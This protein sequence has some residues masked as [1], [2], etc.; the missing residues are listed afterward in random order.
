MAKKPP[1][2]HH[3]ENSMIILGW[4]WTLQ[5]MGRS[6]S[7]C[8]I[9]KNMLDE[10]PL[11]TARVAVTPAATHLFE[12][13]EFCVRLKTSEAELFYHNFSKS[14]FLCKHARPDIQ[15]TVALLCTWVK[16]PDQHD[17]KKLAWTM[18]YLRHTQLMPLT[19]EASDMNVVKWWVDA[20]FVVHP[21]MRRYD[22][23]IWWGLCSLHKTETQHQEFNRKWIGWT[24]WCDATDFLDKQF[25]TSTRLWEQCYCSWTGQK[26][27]TTGAA[28]Q[29][30]NSKRTHHINIRYFFVADRISSGDLDVTYCP[31]SEMLAEY[32]TKPLWLNYEC[33]TPIGYF[34]TCHQCSCYY[35]SKH[36]IRD[37]YG[38]KDC[39]GQ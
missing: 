19:L 20:S 25:S 35:W 22:T 4:N 14:L 31:T 27:Y 28:G 6:A 37:Q 26:S 17:Y 11:E 36:N 7:Q 12:V 10:L 39:V 32:F 13:T 2:C 38:S 23:G 8:L 9:I 30:C 1:W 21:N 34:Q 15:T 3:M 24:T 33:E 18:K 5:L 29:A 16:S